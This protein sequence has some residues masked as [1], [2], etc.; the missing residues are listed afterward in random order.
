MG[1]DPPSWGGFALV[2]GYAEP[3]W[4]VFPDL[5][6]V[7][8]MTDPKFDRSGR[9]PNGR[10]VRRRE[11]HAEAVAK[12]RHVATIS[13]EGLVAEVERDLLTHGQARNGDAADGPGGEAAWPVMERHSVEPLLDAVA[14]LI[15][16][17]RMSVD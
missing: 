15:E 13:L 12:D 6:T 4:L 1:Q 9:R 16:G 5:V 3:G 10:S 2:L 11:F 7:A 8:A 17:D 14:R